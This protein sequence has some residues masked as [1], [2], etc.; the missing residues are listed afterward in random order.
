M[1]RLVTKKIETKLGSIEYYTYMNPTQS[2]V[3]L[4]IHGL[5][6]SRN[7]FPRHFTTY[8]LDRFSWIVPDLLGHRY[9]SKSDKVEAYTMNQQ[10]EYLVSILKKERVEQIVILAHSMGG[11]LQLN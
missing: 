10:V 8:S 3:N 1:K 7:W 11:Q 4:Y 5:G 6:D 9:S 2:I